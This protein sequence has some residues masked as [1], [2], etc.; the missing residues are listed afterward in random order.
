MPLLILGAVVFASVALYMYALNNQ[1]RL[2]KRST[3]KRDPYNVIYLPEDL[4]AYKNRKRN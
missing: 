4:E 2:A 1:E 3:P